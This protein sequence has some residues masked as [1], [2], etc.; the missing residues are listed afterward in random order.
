MAD[1]DKIIADI[2]QAEALNDNAK[3]AKLGKD[4][5]D[6]EDFPSWLEGKADQLG[7]DFDH[8]VETETTRVAESL[9]RGLSKIRAETAQAAR[10]EINKFDGAASDTIE[11]IKDVEKN[12]LEDMEDA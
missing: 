1:R 5:E 10:N 11:E 4:L 3:I 7:S 8:F 9:K 2:S 12:V 6:L